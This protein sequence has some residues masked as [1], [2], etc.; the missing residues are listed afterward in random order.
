[1]DG[2]IAH[3]SAFVFAIRVRASVCLASKEV[4]SALA[5]VQGFQL[6]RLLGTPVSPADDMMQ[7][8]SIEPSTNGE[9][10]ETF[11]YRLSCVDPDRMHRHI[12]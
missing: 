9:N 6:L 11:T 2:L 12:R 10:N 3:C 4:F 1:M 5:D 8:D 7:A